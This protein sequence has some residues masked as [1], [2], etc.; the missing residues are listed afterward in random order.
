MPRSLTNLF[1]SDENIWT[2]ALI[3]LGA[4]LVFMLGKSL[5]SSVAQRLKNRHGHD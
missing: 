1:S 3:G 5:V 2:I 4:V